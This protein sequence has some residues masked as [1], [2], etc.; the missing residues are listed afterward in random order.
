MAHFF[1]SHR[2]TSHKGLNDF[3]KKVFV[4]ISEILILKLLFWDIEKYVPIFD[5]IPQ[6]A[7]IAD[8]YTK[9]IP[10]CIQ[11]SALDFP[12]FCSL[13]PCAA[14]AILDTAK[15][16]H[17]FDSYFAPI[18]TCFASLFFRQNI[19]SKNSVRFWWATT[20]GKVFPCL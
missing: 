2:Q 18:F 1:D 6:C 8:G 13:L 11:F 14:V 19:T 16:C 7:A 10:I 15:Q 3:T 5:K 17:F 20:T 12:Q 9:R 4:T